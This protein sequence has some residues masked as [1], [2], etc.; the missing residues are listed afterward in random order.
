MAA[1]PSELE[2]PTD[3]DRERSARMRV[4][5]R[6]VGIVEREDIQPREGVGQASA[7][8]EVVIPQETIVLKQT[9]LGVN[10]AR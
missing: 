7:R 8:P 1:R 4:G 10:L 3:A 6:D 9:V 5:A 2:R